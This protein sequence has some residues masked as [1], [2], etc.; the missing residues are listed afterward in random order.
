MTE[1]VAFSLFCRIWF[2]KYLPELLLWWNVSCLKRWTINGV[3]LLSIS[4]SLNLYFLSS[5]SLFSDGLLALR[6]SSC[7]ILWFSS[8]SCLFSILFLYTEN[9]IILPLSTAFS[10]SH[11]REGDVPGASFISRKDAHSVLIKLFNFGSCKRD[12]DKVPSVTEFLR[13]SSIPFDCYRGM[14]TYNYGMHC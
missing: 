7:L 3:C 4:L 2:A 12:N 5:F 13:G 10:V 1:I 11:K 9:E 14:I 6:S 8:T